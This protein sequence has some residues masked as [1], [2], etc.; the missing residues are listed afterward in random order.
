MKRILKSK[1]DKFYTKKE[2]AIDLL[3]KVDINEFDVYIDPCCGDGSFYSNVENNNKIGIDILPHIDG[4]IKQDFLEWDYSELIG[5][6]VITISNP[7]FG[8]QGSL[9]LKFIKKCSKF[10]EKIAFILPLSFVK[11]SMKDKIPEYFHL[12]YEEIL[13]EDSFLLDGDNY[14][15]KCVFQVWTKK[16]IK[17]EKSKKIKPIGFD[18]TKDKENADISVRRVGINA[19]KAFKDTNKSAQS[20]YFIILEDKSKI[21]LFI[22][23]LYDSKWDDYTVGPRSISKNELNKFLNELS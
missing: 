8:K 2:L 22:N 21:D 19:G 18:Y 11:E 13:P 9:A 15:V 17:R 1:L 3:S 12:E 5:K 14:D 23:E 4:V 20:H 6:K 16:D 7:P 10:C